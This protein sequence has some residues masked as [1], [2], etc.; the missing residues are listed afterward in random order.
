M[1]HDLNDR[2]GRLELV[3]ALLQ[4]SRKP[5]RK[6]VMFRIA[7]MNFKQGTRYLEFCIDQGLMQSVDDRYVSTDEGARA[8]KRWRGL[9]DLVIPEPEEGLRPGRAS[10][11]TGPPSDGVSSDP[12]GPSRGDPSRQG[13]DEPGP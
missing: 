13:P 7:N 10:F 9:K 6:T 5:V 8:L 2:R 3:M 4:A 11:E 1:V 12:Q